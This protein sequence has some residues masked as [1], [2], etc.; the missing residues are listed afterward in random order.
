MSQVVEAVSSL[1]AP[2]PS[3]GGED[4]GIHSSEEPPPTPHHQP[5]HL[6]SP[7]QSTI[8]TATITTL[9]AHT[10]L[11]TASSASSL[12]YSG[13]STLWVQAIVS[14]ITLTVFA[15][16]P[17]TVTRSSMDR[18]SVSA[19]SKT[20]S[21]GSYLTPLTSPTVEIAGP[22]DASLLTKPVGDTEEG[23][24]RNTP[25]AELDMARFSLEIDGV[26]V[27]FD[28]QEKCTDLIVKVSAVG[29]NLHRQNCGGFATSGGK[30]VGRSSGPWVPYLSSEKILSSKGSALPTELSEI[31]ANSS[32]AGILNSINVCYM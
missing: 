29:A 12:S 20:S 18:H 25:E 11:G 30:G 19:Q 24:D 4:S 26:S 16:L 32:S 7:A 10:S 8:T 1:L 13:F 17:P 14:K 31:L 6:S 23:R 27:Q 15:S 28:V 2:P 3:E 22:I 21:T 5:S 9:P